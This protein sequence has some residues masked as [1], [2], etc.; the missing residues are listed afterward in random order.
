VKKIIKVIK[1]KKIKKIIKIMEEKA[2][3]KALSNRVIK[4]GYPVV[5]RERALEAVR[6]GST[7]AEVRKMFGLGVN[8]LREWE[9]L[10]AATGSL[11]DVPPRRTVYKNDREKLLEYYREN[12]HSTNQETAIAFNCS[13]S[14]IRSA[15]KVL[16]ITRKKTQSG[17]PNVTSKNARN[18]LRK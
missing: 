3:Q 1:I 5:M 14:G 7:K 6:N 16:G 11:K 15:K 13:V 18:L 17:I 10:E 4:M 8:T 12:P 9:K 2:K